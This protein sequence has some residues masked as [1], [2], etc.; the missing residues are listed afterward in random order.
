MP[1]CLLLDYDPNAIEGDYIPAGQ[2]YSGQSMID[3]VQSS[4]FY[5][6][7]IQQGEDAASRLASQQGLR[8]S[9]NLEERYVQNSQN[10]LQ[11]LVGQR[12]QGL[13]GMANLPSNTNAIAGGM[14]GIGTTEAQGIQSQAQIEQQASQNAMNLVGTIG[15]AMIG[16][17]MGASIGG[18][19]GGYAGG[20]PSYQAP[21]TNPMQNYYGNVV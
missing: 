12:L 10:V 8:R 5:G 16:G 15:G 6:S 9:G 14:Q 13:T 4:P 21:A 20:A 1:I 17:P 3:D 2:E 11:N 19:A 7:M 18:Q